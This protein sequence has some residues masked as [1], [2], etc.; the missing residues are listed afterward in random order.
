MT[1]QGL[2][3]SL[4]SGYEVVLLMGAGQLCRTKNPKE[5]RQLKGALPKYEYLEPRDI[6]YAV[7]LPANEVLQEHIKHLLK[8]PAGRPP[9]KPFIRYHDFQYQAKSWDHP[10]RVVA[11]VEW[12]QGQ[13][14][15][16]VGFVMTNLSA[17]PEGVVHSTTGVGWR[18]SG[19]RRVSVS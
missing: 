9:K 8:R 19:L 4:V 1:N 7:R 5:A 14:F 15:P 18:N 3:D 11:K 12:H 17:K 16:R 13:L 10:R 2:T 6:G